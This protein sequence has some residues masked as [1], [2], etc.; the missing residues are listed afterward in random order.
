MHKPTT[1]SRQRHRIQV[2][3]RRNSQPKSPASYLEN[4]SENSVSEIH[5]D[6]SNR[7]NTTSCS[8]SLASDSR[9]AAKVLSP[10]LPA[11]VK[12]KGTN[13]DIIVNVMLDSGSSDCWA[14]ERIVDKLC[15]KTQQTSVQLST[16]ER[17]NS[18]I[19]TRV[20]NNL[21]LS[22][23][24]GQS[25][26][27]IP[28]LYTK[29]NAS[30]P[31]T[32][33]DIPH[34]DDVKQFSHLANIPFS[35]IDSD[36]D[37]LIGMNVP[38][39][40]KPLEIIDGDDDQPFASLHLLGWTINGPVNRASSRSICN[41]MSVHNSDKLNDQIQEFFARDFVDDNPSDS[42]SQNDLKF[43]NSVSSS[44][45]KLPSN[46][47]EIDLPFK[48]SNVTFPSNR[49]QAY[50]RLIG[51]TK[52]FE[53]NP[54]YFQEYDKFFQA[55]IENDFMESIPNNEL[56]TENGKCW[57]LVHH[58]VYHKQKGTLRIVFNCSLNCH[59]T[60]L[61]SMLLQGPDLTSCLLGVLIRFRQESVAIMGDIQKM[62]YQVR[63]PKQHSDFLRLFWFDS[64]G[65]IAEYRLK[66]HVFGATSSPSVANFALRQ[67]ANDN[68][69]STD[70]KD[71]INRA[72]YVDDFLI[73][74]PTDH[75]L[76]EITREVKRTVAQGG[77]TLTKFCSNS[78]SVL[79]SL[80]SD[81]ASPVEI[82]P[83]IE[84]PVCSPSHSDPERALGVIWNTEKDTLSINVK[85]NEQ[86]EP[87]TKRKM[88]KYLS[89][90][91]DPLGFVSPVLIEAKKLFQQACKMKIDWDES[92]SEA[93]LAA[94]N[95]WIT[96]LCTLKLFQVPR[97]FKLDKIATKI[98]MHI[99]ADG[100]ETAYG[101]CTYLKFIYLDGEISVSLISSKSRVTPLNNSTLK[102]IPR[103]ELCSAK[104]AVELADKLSNE[105]SYT[106]SE[107][108]FWSDS[109]TVLHYIRND[110]RRFKRFV[111][112]KV[113][114]I[115]NSSNVNEWHYVPSAENPADLISRG[116]K[117]DK[118]S[119]SSLWTA[120]PKFLIS[121]KFPHEPCQVTCPVDEE[122]RETVSHACSVPVQ[123]PLERLMHSISDWHR[124]KV[125]IAWLLKFKYAVRNGTSLRNSKIS[126]EDLKT[127]E[128][129]I[130]KFV[131]NKFFRNEIN[132]LYA[133]QK[134]SKS[135]AI[136]K[137]TPFLDASGVLRVGGRLRESSLEF[138]IKH[139]IILPHASPIVEMLV[140]WTHSLVGH[141]GR[142]STLARLR[143]NYWVT[144]ANALT[145]RIINHCV[146]CKKYH[147]KPLDQQMSDLPAVRVVGDLPA[148]THTGVDFFGP[149]EVVNGRKV[150]KR[151]G[152]IF[153][154][155]NSRAI[156]LEVAYSLDTDSFINAMRRFICRRGNVTS[157]TSDNGTNLRSGER[158][159]RESIGEWNQNF[160]ESWLK[161]RS[162]SWK[163]N[164]P[165]ASHFGGV[166]EREIRS[167]RKVLSTVF[168]QQILKLND[169]TFVTIL[170][171]VEC[172][173]N[174]R[175]LTK[176]SDD[177]NDINALTPN[178]LLLCNSGI[179][180]P[181]GLFKKEES[182]LRRKW[183]QLQYLVDIFWTRWRKEYL[184]LLN[185]RQKWHHQKPSLQ[186]NDIVLVTDLSLPRN[187]W[188]LGRVIEIFPDKRGLVRSVNVKVAKCRDNNLKNFNS[189]ILHR[190]IS[191]LVLLPCD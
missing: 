73:S 102:T 124:L 190:P 48:S 185:Q 105:L 49:Q 50:N 88:L 14:N 58:G 107:R 41:R 181:P 103:I 166:Y 132:A 188:P 136:R 164:P 23:L 68:E 110:D 65:K 150:S 180:F 140:R 171:E 51:S 64:R 17:K 71:A 70:A 15:I 189:V 63:V 39:L 40:L 72:F 82:Y 127:S 165:S 179:T 161:Q 75:K 42:I 175:P 78:S 148:F 77:F 34:F 115:R 59:N 120:G 87:L 169:E 98:E 130:I 16:M 119:Q 133:K 45:K 54:N 20:I 22:S 160:I 184:I 173:L 76:L 125:R 52:K 62:F 30:W 60:S 135:S 7:V 111:S 5:S 149:F 134:I 33:E 36:V 182:Y 191:K 21:E 117:V 139:P 156:H 3:D 1:P 157:M 83:A 131:Q 123:T 163:F 104:L 129:V 66:V 28:V 80:S 57:Y 141:L 174:N 95:L 27:D 170:C 153:T 143:K 44:I 55:M 158:E 84:S 137:L 2:E 18:S 113:S 183:R 109:T 46:N 19:N 96:D 9:G 12:V 97:C 147:A 108:T 152:V 144:R 99:F 186:L 31:F 79:H 94:W 24:D 43:T 81:S 10:I 61:N 85:P 177:P 142:E 116:V 154:C 145:R 90:I 138:S 86:S 121:G 172:I 101:A 8:T 29:S 159:L 151:Y 67:T 13:Q 6:R 176:I 187:Q 168:R 100:S 106:I 35:F 155:M 53:R 37:I 92:P 112:N 128:T 162:I 56:I 146:T 11:K 32:K 26:T 4:T 118:L 38:M 69:C 167:V 89:C 74:K 91:Y 178:H 122:E 126:V 93:I 25:V 114:F 47:Y